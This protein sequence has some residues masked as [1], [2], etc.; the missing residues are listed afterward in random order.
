MSTATNGSAQVGIPD[1]PLRVAV[2]GAGPAGFYAVQA[3][4]AHPGLNVEIDV[5]DR[6]PTPFGL[7]RSGVAP[8]H[9]KIKAVSA[10]YH[11]LALRLGFRFFGNVEYGKDISLDDLRHNYHQIVFAQGAQNDR[12]LGIPGE[13]LNGVHSARE[14]VAWY[15]GDPRHAHDEFDFTAKGAVVVGVGNVAADVARILCRSHDKLAA[16]DI[17]DYA[18]E[19]LRNSSVRNVWVLG[20]RGPVQSKISPPEV[21]ELAELTE[22][23]TSVPAA[24]MEL[25]PYSQAELDSKMERDEAHRKH[26]AL[27]E[28]I[29]RREPDKKRKLVLRFLVSPVEILGDDHGRVRALKI[30]KNELYQDDQGNIRPRATNQFEEIECG[31][32]F[33]SVGYKG[34]AAPELP[35]DERNGVIPNVQGRVFDPSGDPEVIGIYATGWIKRGP[36]GLI[37]SNKA[38]AKETVERMLEDLEASSIGAPAAAGGDEIV[39]LLESRGTRYVTYEDWMKIDAEEIA[40]GEAQGRPRVKITE[41]EEMLAVL[42]K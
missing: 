2:V 35:F 29:D 12:R 41:V 21:H 4:F 16:T 3:L 1:K 8:D 30:V 26:K 42:G 36:S 14:F 11:K 20:R 32:V 19:A 10:L 28:L 5:F 15:N 39:S 7:V 40:R 37:G 23:E 34:V 9:P 17:A 13:E 31:L 33:R 24:D 22:T 18:L 6:L 27:S 25:D 38:C